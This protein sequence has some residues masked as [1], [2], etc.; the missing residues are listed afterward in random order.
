MTTALCLSVVAASD[1]RMIM[2]GVSFNV[3]DS[4]DTMDKQWA[5]WLDQPP[6]KAI[7]IASE[8]A[9]RADILAGNLSGLP[10]QCSQKLEADA[11][12]LIESCHGWRGETECKSGHCYCKEGY[13]ASDEL[14]TCVKAEPIGDVDLVCSGGGDL[15]AYHLGMEMIFG[16]M[17]AKSSAV[18][19]Q[20]R[21]G[22]SGGG[23][24]TFEYVLKGENRTLQ[25]YLSYGLLQEAYPLK[26][27]TIASTVL[28]QDHHWRMMA[29]WQADK[30]SSSLSS[31]DDR[32][33]LALD[34]GWTDSK[35]KMVSKYTSAEQAASAFISTGA[36]SQIYEGDL[37]A[38]GSSVSGDDM[39]PLFQDKVRQQIIVNLMEVGYKILNMGGGKFNSAD[40]VKL[41]Q[42][43][44]DEAVEYIR[45]RTVK[46]N[47]KVITLCPVGADVHKNVCDKTAIKVFV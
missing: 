13:C 2:G 15:N 26:F 34:C 11:S 35:L 16:R 32:V 25:S 12:C 40:F 18:R 14:N 29:K 24:I 45:T 47:N 4:N 8:L 7:E 6:V 31:L 46:R 22:A 28:L 23:W 38:D 1:S 37:C 30:W 39:T 41:V 33:F 43:G 27:A 19:R 10:T 5:E 44:Q 21:G 9:T 17:E 20:R 42:L 36:I 3:N